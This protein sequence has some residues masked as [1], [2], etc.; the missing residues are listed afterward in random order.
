MLL[1]IHFFSSGA[2][3]ASLTQNSV[4][5]FA[6]GFVVHHLADYL[7]HLDTNVFVSKKYLSLRDFNSPDDYKKIVLTIIEFVIFLLI[8]FY[9]IGNKS[10]EI[11]KIAVWGGIGGL[12]PDLLNFLNIILANR[13]VRF[14][15]FRK[16]QLFHRDFH[17]R[18]KNKIL[19]ALVQLLFFLFSLVLI[20]GL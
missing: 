6:I 7:P 15:W 1:G 12:F 16:Y 18:G 10:L 19:A 11:Q 2:V 9:L 8:F 20:L 13:L 3:A 4:V 14:S 5:A 17:F